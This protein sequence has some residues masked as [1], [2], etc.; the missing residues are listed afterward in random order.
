MNLIPLLYLS[1]APNLKGNRKY[2]LNKVYLQSFLH[3]ICTMGKE[4]LI[5]ELEQKS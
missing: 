4:A 5:K 1:T 3:C 2:R